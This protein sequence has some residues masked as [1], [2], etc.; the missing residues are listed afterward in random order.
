MDI[1]V[2]NVILESFTQIVS[3]SNELVYGVTRGFGGNLNGAKTER[4]ATLRFAV[5]SQEGT[6]IFSQFFCLPNRY[7]ATTLVYGTYQATAYNYQVLEYDA[8]S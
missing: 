3:V 5:T 7:M 1:T 8:C 6:K 4:E 2:V